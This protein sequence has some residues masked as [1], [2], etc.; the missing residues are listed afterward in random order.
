[1]VVFL[2]NE[3]VEFYAL[4]HLLGATKNF[5]QFL[6]LWD[7]H[8]QNHRNEEAYILVLEPDGGD[9]NQANTNRK[10]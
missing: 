7:Y 2:Q 10:W 9:L 3:K 8:T 6:G 5:S 1:M 4:E